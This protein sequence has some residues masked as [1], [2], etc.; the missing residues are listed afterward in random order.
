VSEFSES[1]HLE[2]DRQQAGIHLL[3]RANL[4]GV[5]FPQR[6]GWVTILPRSKF[7]QLPEALIHANQGMLL[8][9]LLD[10]DA[11]WMFEVFTGP[12]LACHYQCRWL[13]W[14]DPKDPIKIH[15]NDLDIEMV[16][17]LAKRHGHGPQVGRRLERILHPRLERRT[18]EETGAQF[19]GFADWDW[20][21]LAAYAFAELVALPHYEWLRWRDDTRDEGRW[22]EHGAVRLRR[23]RRR[24]PSLWTHP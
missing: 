8:R 6:H 3:Q 13:D 16:Q 15:A 9:Y 12:K 18:D 17:A 19:D 23:P 21:H 14:S 11:G 5:V 4:D 20:S 22:V 7:G 2:T 1:Y 10:E 24:F